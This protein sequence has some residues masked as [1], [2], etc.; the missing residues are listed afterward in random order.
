MAVG[1]GLRC[2]N[3]PT[4]K[5]INSM[6][7]VLSNPTE[8]LAKQEVSTKLCM[9]RHTKSAF[10]AFIKSYP[11]PASWIA[12]LPDN[13][14]E[15]LRDHK[16]M[17]D[18][19]FKVGSD[20]VPSPIDLTLLLSY[21]ASYG[22]RGGGRCPTTMAI[23]NPSAPPTITTM[24]VNESAMERFAGQVM[25]NMQHMADNQR[26]L[27]ETLIMSPSPGVSNRM[28]KALNALMLE[29]RATL[30]NPTTPLP[31]S[32]AP[33]AVPRSPVTPCVAMRRADSVDSPPALHE[34]D[35]VS[36]PHVEPH[37]LAIVPAK[38]APVPRAAGDIDAMLDMMVDRKAETAAKKKAAAAAASGAPPV[39]AMPGV[40]VPVAKAVPEVAV[41]KGKAVPKVAAP[42]GKAVPKVAAPKGKAVP[43]VTSPTAKATSTKTKAVH[44][45]APAKEKAVHKAA[46]PKVDAGTIDGLTL[47]CS[48]CRWN[49]AGCGQCH[50][51]AF[52]GLRWNAS[53]G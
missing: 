31:L 27:M 25:Q 5:L 45:A 7:M 47:G 40:A 3:E 53:L 28:P 35:G 8:S 49:P 44:K 39:E 34:H 30:A 15:L 1:L 17:Y 43:K 41:P 13:P 4:S 52:G 11:D 38:A 2:P 37:Q 20:P 19:V 29:D 23:A 10:Q 22:C 24:G 16:D 12:K 46:T 21:N 33:A 48:K 14:T 42:K 26:R 36:S 6:W 9:L 18:K 50:N 32:L 51:P